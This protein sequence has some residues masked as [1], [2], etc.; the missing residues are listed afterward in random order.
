MAQP[1]SYRYPL[2]DGHGNWGSPTIRKS[3]AAMRLYRIAIA[4]LCACSAGTEL[5]QGTVDW[6][7][8]FDGTLKE[9]KMLLARL[10]NPLLNGGQRDRRGTWRSI[11]HPITCAKLSAPACACWMSLQLYAGEIGRG[12]SGTRFSRPVARSSPRARICWTWTRAVTGGNVRMR[13]T[14]EQVDDEIIVNALMHQVSGQRYSS[15][16]PPRCRLRSCRWL[17]IFAD[18]SDHEHPTR[19]V[20]MP[21]SNRVDLDALMDHLFATTDLERSTR[22]NLNMIGNDVAGRART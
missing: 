4:T 7:P 3:F 11:F 14:W 10:P 15:R 12:Y 19:L 6:E 17:R 13:A 9:P 5:G 22:V 1:F 2:V 16:L 20:I 8:N 18:E 21:R